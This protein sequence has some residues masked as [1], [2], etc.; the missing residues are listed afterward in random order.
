MPDI[1]TSI[2]NHYH[3]R[4]KYDP[5]T[6]NSKN[7]TLDWSKQPVPFKDYKIGNTFDLK[8]YLSD[9]SRRSTDSTT[10]NWVRLSLILLCSYGLTAKLPTMY[11]SYVYLRSAP[12]A[13]GLYPA[14]VYLISHGTPILPAGLY[15]YQPQNHSLVHFW[16]NEVWSNLQK[17]CFSHPVL[18][19]TQLAIVTTAIFYR[20]A[21]RYEDRAYRRIFLDT[22]H[23]LGNLELACAFNNYRPHLIGGFQDQ[24]MNQL[25]YLDSDR[26]GVITVIPLEDL[27]TGGEEVSGGSTA[28]PSAIH[29]EYPVIPDGELLSYFHQAT[30]ITNSES[31]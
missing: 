22:G 19:N 5:Q 4:T 28:L 14:E 16:E 25:L 9:E 20:S 31:P 8:P 21:W 27:L 11:G 30:Q 13:G 1:Q 7:K 10:Q 15:N 17:A 6:I 29:T 26:E 23:L 12:S 2:A 3:Q 18:E 24:A